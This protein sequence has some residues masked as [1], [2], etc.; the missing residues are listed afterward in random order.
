MLLHA[1]ANVIDITRRAEIGSTPCPVTG[2][3]SCLKA[4]RLILTWHTISRSLHTLKGKMMFPRGNFFN[5]FNLYLLRC[6]GSRLLD[7]CQTQK[8]LDSHVLPECGSRG[9][10][11]QT[12]TV[13]LPSLREGEGRILFSSRERTATMDTQKHSFY[14]RYLVIQ[15]RQPHSPLYLLHR[16]NKVQTL[17]ITLQAIVDTV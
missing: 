1:I 9:M 14:W 7:H 3:K 10:L 13:I 4:F 11:C 12:K 8:T 5:Q 15:I 17:K 6:L 16:E 2:G